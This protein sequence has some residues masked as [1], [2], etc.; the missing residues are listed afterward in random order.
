MS[1]CHDALY[2]KDRVHDIIPEYPRTKHL[3]FKANAKR[4]DLIAS[5]EECKSIWTSN[6]ATQEKIDGAN[7]R[8]SLDVE[9][10]GALHPLIGN[11]QH[12]INKSYSSEKI[13]TPAKQQFKPTWNWWYEH[14][15]NFN[16]LDELGPYSVYGDW[17]YMQH[18]MHYDLLPSLFMTYDVYDYRARAFLDPKLALAILEECGFSVVP[19]LHYGPIESFEQLETW[20]NEP[21]PFATDAKREGIYLKVSNGT[22]VVDRF[23]MVREGFEQGKYLSEVLLRNKLKGS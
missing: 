4:D 16:K 22:H 1:V 23:K 7:C 9:T 10:N 5:P 3:C 21:T 14:K 18:G 11:R 8:M 2:R 13:R 19:L 6:V 15:E 20:A 17:M 12:I